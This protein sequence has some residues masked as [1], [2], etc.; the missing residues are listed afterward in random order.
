VNT[1]ITRLLILCKNWSP[2]LFE[3]EQCAQLLAH[4]CDAC[5][6]FRNGSQSRCRIDI[7]RL[8]RNMSSRVSVSRYSRYVDI[9]SRRHTTHD[10]HMS[11][12]SRDMCP[13]I[14]RY[15]DMLSRFATSIFYSSVRVAN[16]TRLK[17]TESSAD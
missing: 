6:L 10:T 16:G 8:F 1:K 13:F 14:S 2:V 7:V 4:M 15:V 11:I 3:K 17:S 9:L 12:S 5:R